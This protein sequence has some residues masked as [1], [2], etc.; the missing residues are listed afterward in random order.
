MTTYTRADS[1][2]PLKK[3]QEY[4]ADFLNSFD[5]TPIGNQLGKVTNENA[6]NQ[7]IMNL[8]KTNLGER[9]FQPGIGGNVYNSLF[10]NVSPPMLNS[11]Q[12]FIERT[13]KENEPRVVLIGVSVDS[14]INY[15]RLVYNENAVE[16]TVRYAL[17]NNPEETVLNFILKRIR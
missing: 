5:K 14:P 16:I 8:V 17:I 12:Y 15:S 3:K 6:V 13:I 9:L 4:F 10:E 11:L 2:T 1:F 7:S